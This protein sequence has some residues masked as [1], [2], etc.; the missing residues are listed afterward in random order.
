MIGFFVPSLGLFSILSHWQAEQYPFGIRTQLNL[1]HPKDQ[2]H[3]YNL[4][5]PLLWNDLDR[6]NY[7]EDVN[8]PTPPPYTLYT[9]FTL[10]WTFVTFG[11]LMF[12]HAVSMMMVKLFTSQ[13]FK[14][15]RNTFNKLMHVVQNIHCSFPYKDWDEDEAKSDTKEE[16]KKRFQNT[17]NEMMMSQL[18]NI[19]VSMIMLIPI[20]FSGEYTLSL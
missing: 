4:T 17:E 19:C 5:E 20:W 9:G 2:V 11:L 12:F 13:E 14:E 16:F 3:L 8:E 7:Y 18:L 15:E 6:W 1:I 10:K